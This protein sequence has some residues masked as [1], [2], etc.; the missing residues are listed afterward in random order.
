M[1]ST[2]TPPVSPKRDTSKFNPANVAAAIHWFRLA[3]Q[4]G[5]ELSSQ[6]LS[7]H[8]DGLQGGWGK[9]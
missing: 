8:E 1:E 9:D 5:D 3:A 4:Q 6:W 7:Q 2:P